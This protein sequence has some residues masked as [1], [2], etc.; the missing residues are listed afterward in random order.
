LNL[1]NLLQEV[2]LG[3]ALA[4]HLMLEDEEKAMNGLKKNLLA[5]VSQA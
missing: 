3:L 2:S 4:G 1:V 5:F